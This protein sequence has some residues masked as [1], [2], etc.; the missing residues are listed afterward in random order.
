MKDLDLILV[1]NHCGSI[2]RKLGI[3]ECKCGK[4]DCWVAKSDAASKRKINKVIIP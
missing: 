4:G 1:C 3:Y 2:K